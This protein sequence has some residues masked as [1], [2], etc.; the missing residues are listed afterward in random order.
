M[1]NSPTRSEETAADIRFQALA[2]AV[3]LLV[4]AAWLYAIA[5]LLMLSLVPLAV[6]VGVCLGRR[7]ERRA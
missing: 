7:L 2:W 4:A 3:G 5:P 1:H 6:F